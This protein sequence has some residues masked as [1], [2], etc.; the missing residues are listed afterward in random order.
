VGVLGL[1]SPGGAQSNAEAGEKVLPATA[2]KDLALTS[3]TTIAGYVDR[4]E[5]VVRVGV[6]GLGRGRIGEEAS[7]DMGLG[8]GCGKVEDAEALQQGGKVEERIDHGMV[9]ARDRDA[10]VPRVGGLG[11][12]CVE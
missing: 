8:S 1:G 11:S 4:G 2:P 3:V 9:G 12:G 6:D 7:T 10:E 5:E